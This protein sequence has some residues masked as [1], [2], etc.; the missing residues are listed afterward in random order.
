MNRC[1]LWYISPF[2]SCRVSY[3]ID[4]YCFIPNT[5]ETAWF[6]KYVYIV[7]FIDYD[8]KAV[9][10]SP[11]EMFLEATYLIVSKG[12]SV[13]G[14]SGFFTFIPELQLSMW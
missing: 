14:Y 6:Y 7:A 12:G 8:V 5:C 3:G 1:I 9:F 4:S 2:F 10:G 11:W 13:S